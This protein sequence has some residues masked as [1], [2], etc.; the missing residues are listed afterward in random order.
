M[1]EQGTTLPKLVGIMRQ[2][3]GPEGCPW[4]RKQ[5]LESLRPYVIEEA[6]EVVDAIDQGEPE[7]LREELGD[8]LLQVVFQAELARSKGWFGADGVIDAIC[9]KLVRRHP[10]VFGNEPVE[11]ADDAMNQWERIKAEEKRLRAER[12]LAPKPTGALSGVP[13]ALPALLRAMRVGEKASAAGFDWLDAQ[14][15]R[16][17][18]DEELRELDEAVRNGDKAHQQDELGDVLFALA[19]FARKQGLDAEA[20]LR[21]TL[22]RFSRRF[23]HVEEQ[24]ETAGRS[25]KNMSQDE[26]DELW[27]QAKRS[28]RES[29]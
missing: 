25:L 23:R 21:G 28:V 24:A 14:G 15:P 8:L 6:F 27:N 19:N 26:L 10:W 29:V 17:K 7:A 5:T 9:E 2:L 3:L 22:D 18:V 4:D 13:V 16:E 1:D 11:N 20:A 12:G